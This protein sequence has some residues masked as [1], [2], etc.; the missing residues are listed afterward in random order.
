MVVLQ[1]F[2]CSH[3]LAMSTLQGSTQSLQASSCPLRSQAGHSSLVCHFSFVV[4]QQGFVLVLMI[5]YHLFEILMLK[6]L[7]FFMLMI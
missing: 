1:K 3:H 2:I 4:A 5:L 7:F 6:F